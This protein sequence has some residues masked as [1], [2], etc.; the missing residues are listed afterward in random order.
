MGQPARKG[1]KENYAIVTARFA[2]MWTTENLG[3]FG[4]LRQ[5]CGGDSVL[6]GMINKRNYQHNTI[7]KL[8]FTIKSQ[9][10]IYFWLLFLFFF[11]I[12]EVNFCKC[13]H[14]RRENLWIFLGGEVV[15]SSSMAA[16]HFVSPWYKSCLMELTPLLTGNYARKSLHFISW[17]KQNAVS[18]SSPKNMAIILHCMWLAWS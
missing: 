5:T 3:H 7:C 1:Q 8:H 15:I 10:S 13:F 16:F 11:S 17:W 2:W 9:I 12:F 4:S 14:K 6:W 18:C